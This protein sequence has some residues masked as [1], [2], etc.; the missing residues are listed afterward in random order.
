[1]ERGSGSTITVVQP[2]AAR[3]SDFVARWSKSNLVYLL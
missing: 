3:M 2:E 1:M